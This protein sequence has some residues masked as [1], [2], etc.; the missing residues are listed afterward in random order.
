VPRPRRAP[1]PPGRVHVVCSHRAEDRREPALIKVVQATAHEESPGGIMFTALGGVP[2][3]GN[4]Y[5]FRCT[6]CR[7][8]LKIGKNRFPGIVV[9]LATQQGTRGDTPVLVDISRIERAL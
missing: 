6:A 1:A 2:A 4:A 9:A 3:E 7:R 8:H 5:S